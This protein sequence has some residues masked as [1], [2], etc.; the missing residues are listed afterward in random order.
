MDCTL[1]GA[2]DIGC[3]QICQKSRKIGCVIPHCN[4]QRG[5]TQPILRLFLTYL[6]MG[7]AKSFSD[8]AHVAHTLGGRQDF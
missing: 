4:L 2:M 3:L 8:V 7:C 6:Y 1:Q 5:I